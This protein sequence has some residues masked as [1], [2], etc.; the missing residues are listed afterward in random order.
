MEDNKVKIAVDIFGGDNAPDV[1]IQ[2]V[3]QA[4]SEDSDIIIYAVGNETVVN[5]MAKADKRIIPVAANEVIG[6]AEHPVEAI[7]KKK[8]ATIP[9]AARLIKDGTVD[10]FFSAGSTGAMLS[11]GTL[12]AGR[13][14]GVKR[15]AIGALLPGYDHPVLMMDVGA[16]ADCKPEMLLQFAQIGTAYMKSVCGVAEPKVGLLN[17]GEEDEKGNA[18]SIDTNKL[19]RKKLDNFYGNCEGRDLMLDEFDVVVCDGFTGNVALKTIE[20]TGKLMFKFLKDAFMS[21]PTT[22]ISAALMSSQLKELKKKTDSEEQG[23]SPLL[24][25]K[26]VFVIGHG[27]SGAKGIK[28][29]I[30]ETAKTV[31]CDLSKAIEDAIK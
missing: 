30:L 28:N 3:F 27:S 14:R 19:L 24:G 9:V 16:N 17:I 12:I 29:G 7:R 5:E 25:T 11:A 22:K 18:F 20:G 23:G 31:R 26:G 8:D 2:G 1:C 4:L 13:I 6:M 10:G 15:P 21:G